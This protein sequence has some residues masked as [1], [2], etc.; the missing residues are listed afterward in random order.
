MVDRAN[1]SPP[2]P[3]SKTDYVLQRLRMDISSGAIK[4]GTPLRQLEIAE[5]YGVSATPVRE[6]MRLLEADGSITYSRHRGVTVN[7][8]SSEGIR[9][10]YRL[11]S[12]AEGLAVE[13]AVERMDQA[14]LVKVIAAHDRLA[15][16]GGNGDG[17]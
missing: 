4:A 10:L 12:L 2:Q 7:E 1:G 16:T 14:H 5:R 8:M 6:A 13:V 15:A 11:R 9:D 17:V 3:V